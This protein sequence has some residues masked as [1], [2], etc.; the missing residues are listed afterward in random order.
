MFDAPT[1]TK[2][3]HGHL[4]ELLDTMLKHFRAL[5]ALKRPTETW[6]DLII[7]I[8]TSKLDPTTGKAW[9]PVLIRIFQI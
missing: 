9:E 6:D 1:L 4:R 2:E 7:H 5:K 3:N 8:I